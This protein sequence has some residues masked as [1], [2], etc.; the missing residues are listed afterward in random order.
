MHRRLPLL[1]LFPLGIAAG[2]GAAADP[3]RGNVSLAGELRFTDL[4]HY[5][6]APFVVPAGTDRLTIVFAHNGAPNKTTIDLGL[7]DPER[8]RGWSGGTRTSAP[9]SRHSSHRRLC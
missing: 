7:R 2:G 1:A 3:G 5:V 9:A 8:F 6:E 4:H